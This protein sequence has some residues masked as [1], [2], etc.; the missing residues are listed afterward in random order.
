M[1]IIQGQNFNE[2]RNKIFAELLQNKDLIKA[3]VIDGED[4]LNVSPTPSQQDL[5]DNPKKLIRSHIYPYKKMFDTVTEKKVMITTELTGFKKQ[6]H[7]YRNGILT[8]YILVPVDLENTNYGI[9]YDFI[10]DTI[11]T[12]FANTTIGELNFLNRGDIDIGNGYIGHY[13][14]FQIVE[15]HIVK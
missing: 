2:L 3:I 12:I 9:R 6:G 11:E 4:F 13:V 15:F 7:N 5:I 8:F 1:A 14:S 10:G